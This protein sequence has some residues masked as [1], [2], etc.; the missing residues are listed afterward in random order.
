MHCSA[1]ENDSS[2]SL[3][4]LSCW[5]ELL[6]SY[7]Y[8]CLHFFLLLIFL[9]FVAISLLGPVVSSSVLREQRPKEMLKRAGNKKSRREMH[10][11]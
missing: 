8:L 4:S 6:T 1:P 3:I 11:E 5:I 2:S 10:A 7:F 9:S